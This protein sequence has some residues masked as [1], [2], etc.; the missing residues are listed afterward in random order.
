VSVPLNP[1]VGG[2]PP[3]PLVGQEL[4]DEVAFL[5]RD[6]DL[7]GQPYDPDWDRWLAEQNADPS[8]L[9]RD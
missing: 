2:E 5:K 7:T 9:P 6:A 8:G 1:Y 4:E 3:L